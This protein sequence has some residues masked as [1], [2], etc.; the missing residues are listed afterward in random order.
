MAWR[1]AESL[2]KLR[3]QV[4][5]MAPGRSTSSDGTIGDTSHRARKS[6]HNPNDA[7]VVTAMDITHDPAHGVDSGEIAEMLR[8]SRD[9]RI[10]YVIS[11]RRIFSSAVSPWQWRPYSGS[12]AHTVHVHVSVM[13]DP[14]LYDDTAPWQIE[15]MARISAPVLAPSSS[16]PG[17]TNVVA[18]V[19]G[20]HADRN[21]SA[22]DGHVI[23]D[24]ELG[25]ALPFRFPNERPKVRVTNLSNGRSAVCAIVD[26]GPWNTQDPY[27][28]TNAR[29]QAETGTDLRGRPTNR[30]G[31]DLTPG[32]AAAI[33]LPGKGLVN[34][35]FADAVVAPRQPAQPPAADATLL[36][37]Q[38]LQRTM[39]DGGQKMPLQPDDVSTLLQQLFRLLQGG[40]AA[41]GPVINPTPAP[42]PAP[43][44]AP[45]PGTADPT[46]LIFDLIASMLIPAITKQ[47][48]ALGPVNG[49]LGTTVGNMLDGKK[50]AIGIFGG[51]ISSLLPHLVPGA[52]IAGDVAAA[53]GPLAKVATLAPQFGLPV[54]LAL[55]AWGALGKM[56]KWAGRSP[57]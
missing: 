24:Q 19:F 38:L 8:L 36:L 9:R 43:A 55:T 7:G 28:L 51:V 12:N 25:I 5:A 22:Y 42:T 10:K 34:W 3:T 32:A 2:V 50:S 40:G 29:P 35:E 17:C 46:K 33:G 18:T 16:A 23:D 1:P 21:T 39:K 54:F 26:V 4:N 20:G 11:N 14:A 48:P 27:W 15:R 37:L 6:D 30:A 49:A 31:I 53:A 44:P 57:N 52:S 41:P 47:P 56:E 45:S 13:D